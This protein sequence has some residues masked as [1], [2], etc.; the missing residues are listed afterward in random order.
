[1]RLV[2][3]GHPAPN[4]L[5]LVDF[6]AT[7]QRP[8][9]R[10]RHDQSRLRGTFCSFY[11]RYMRQDPVSAFRP[12]DFIQTPWCRW[13]ELCPTLYILKFCNPGERVPLS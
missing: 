13:V 12:D 11:C 2:R 10:I 1:M 8:P 9:P 5:H 4:S 6:G 3:L 7:D